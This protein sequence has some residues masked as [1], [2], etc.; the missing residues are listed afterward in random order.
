MGEVGVTPAALVAEFPAAAV[1][2]APVRHELR[3][4]LAQTIPDPAR[5]YDL[6]LAA[7]EACSNSIEHGHHGDQ[8]TIRLE[9]AV[10]NGNVRITIADTGQW[11]SRD[12]EPD[13]VRGRTDSHR[14]RGLAIIRALVPDTSVTVIE[15]GTTV[16]LIAPLT[17]PE[18][19]PTGR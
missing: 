12:H 1:E 14:G 17:N 8:R 3:Q 4:W 19:T 18:T 13:S 9:A 10:E 2:L 11:L 16:E 7:G 5:A 15:S 6:L